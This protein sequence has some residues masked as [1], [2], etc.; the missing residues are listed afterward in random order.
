MEQLPQKMQTIAI[1]T[2]WYSANITSCHVSCILVWPPARPSG[3]APTYVQLD[4]ET[5]I[6]SP[7]GLVVHGQGC[8]NFDL[9]TCQRNKFP[10]SPCRAL[11]APRKRRQRCH[12]VIRLS[13]WMFCHS[14]PFGKYAWG[15]N[16]L[17]LVAIQN[18]NKT[19]VVHRCE[20]NDSR[21]HLSLSGVKT[22]HG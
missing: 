16:Q 2:A 19:R 4:G 1:T 11:W 21:I 22:R 20:P 10:G 9:N 18:R 5:A 15:F 8:Q 13:G 14:F 3:F 12:Q 7:N 17:P 6:S